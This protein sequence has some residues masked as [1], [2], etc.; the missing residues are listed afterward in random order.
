MEGVRGLWGGE[1]PKQVLLPK[2]NLQEVFQKRQ[3]D[4][5]KEQNLERR[6]CFCSLETWKTKSKEEWVRMDDKEGTDYHSR[7]LP[8]SGH[9]PV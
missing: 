7:F 4:S 1:E 3:R 2:D 9:S 5:K 8:G 6:C